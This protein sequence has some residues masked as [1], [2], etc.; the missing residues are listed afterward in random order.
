VCR[1]EGSCRGDRWE[2]CGNNLDQT[3]NA[4]GDFCSQGLYCCIGNGEQFSTCRPNGY[5]DPIDNWVSCI[6]G[7]TTCKPKFDGLPHTCCRAPN[8]FKFTCRPRGFCA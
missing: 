6:P 4:G 7:V 1:P 2:R 5:C 8:D 3:L